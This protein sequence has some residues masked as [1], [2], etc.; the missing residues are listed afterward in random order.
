MNFSQ[1]ILKK[2]GI[3]DWGYTEILESQSFERLN[4]W[5]LNGQH[6]PLG[7]LADHRKDLRKSL[8]NYYP[9]CQSSLVF[10]FGYAESK[11]TL[12][13]IPEG[14]KIASYVLGFEGLDYH[15]ELKNRLAELAKEVLEIYPGT[16]IKLSLDTQPIL[17][18]DLA[19][20]AGLGWFGKN[21]MLIHQQ[22]GSYFLIGSLLLNK[23]LPIG[24]KTLSTD[25]CGQCTRCI[26]A[27]PTQAIDPLNRTLKADLCIST[28]TIEV[29]KDAPPPSGFAESGKIFGCDICQEVCPWNESP[30]EKVE[31]KEFGEAEQLLLNDFIDRDKETILKDLEK[32]YS[33]NSYQKKY[34]DTPLARTG[35]MGMIKNL[36]HLK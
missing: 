18:R 6:G 9:E 35:R 19:Y 26:D 8:T 28:F 34:R 32:N 17:E 29:F 7:Y 22:F 16:D 11:K 2:L 33:N 14:L 24:F 23:K 25:H 27:C 13:H 36:Y 21:S 4:Q 30:I 31:Y 5:V 12:N 3:L 20:R 1:K 10:L 15:L